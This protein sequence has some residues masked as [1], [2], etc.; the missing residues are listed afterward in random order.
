M[1]DLSNLKLFATAPHPCSYLDHQQATTLF[2][3]PDA[4]VDTQLYSQLSQMGFRRSG[5]H[6]YR[7]HCDRCQ[8]C[9]SSRVPVKLFKPSRSQKR[10]L[11]RN[12]DITCSLVDDITSDEHY[13]LYEAYI[14]TRHQDGDMYPAT[15]IQY[16]A[17]LNSE[18]GVTQHIEY[19]IGTRLIGLATCD[20]LEDGLSAVYTFFDPEE[21]NRSLGVFSILAQIQQAERLNLHY[22]YLGYWIRECNKM[23]YKTQY[24]PLELL[25]NKRWVQ[26]V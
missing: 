3:D 13:A 21:A 26:L 14:N 20:L 4:K 23:A 12:K 7:P 15:R 9:I 22:V 18:W 19:R 25:I 10:C 8:A 2:V 17:F 24:N 16:D 5:S 1:S 6:L 11:K